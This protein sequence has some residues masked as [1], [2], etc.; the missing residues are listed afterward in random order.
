V[1]APDGRTLFY[2]SGGRMM[3]AALTFAPRFDVARR[4]TLFTDTFTGLGS[5]RQFD[6]TP[7][8][9]QFLMLRRGDQQ[10]RLVVVFGWL[11]ELKER[12]ALA[13]KK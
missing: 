12:M 10:Q 5:I 1:W 4:D 13:T 9:R 8:G 11:D 3:A 6:V 7:D 2:R